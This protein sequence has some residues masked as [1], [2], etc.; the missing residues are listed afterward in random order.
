MEQGQG[1]GFDYE[2]KWAFASFVEYMREQKPGYH[3]SKEDFRNGME[4]L[5]FK[6]D[7]R[8]LGKVGIGRNVFL[9]IRPKQD[10]AEPL[11]DDGEGREGDEGKVVPFPSNKSN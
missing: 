11:F 3:I 10:S 7:R 2:A 1:V 6:Y 8:T 5:G 4:K 9:G